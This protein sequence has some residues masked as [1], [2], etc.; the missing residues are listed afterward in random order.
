MNIYLDIDGVL[1]ADIGTSEEILKVYKQ[2]LIKESN[3]ALDN[4]N[5]KIAEHR[6]K[7]N[8]ISIMRSKAIDRFVAEELTKDEK[9]SYIESLDN[10]KMEISSEL[11]KLEQ[12]QMIRETDIEQAIN[13]ME[14]VDKQWAVSEIDLQLRFQSMLFPRGVVYDS[15]SHKFGTSEISELYRCIS[16]KK[17]PEGALNSHLVAGAGLGHVPRP[18]NFIFENKFSREGFL[19]NCHWQ[20]SPPTFSV[21]DLSPPAR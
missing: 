20:F 14:S 8:E 1:L 11:A 15:K 6:N 12:Q 7:L 17:A 4:L 21:G 9:D 13:V 2:V 16:M 18:R 3:V 19:A 10:Q 5:T